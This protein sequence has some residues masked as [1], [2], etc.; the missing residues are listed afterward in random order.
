MGLKKGTNQ[1]SQLLSSWKDLPRFWREFSE[2]RSKSGSNI[3]K[4]LFMFGQIL[5]G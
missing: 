1:K 2:N 3:R 5:S 4:P